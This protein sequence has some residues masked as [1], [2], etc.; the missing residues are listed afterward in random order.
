[1]FHMWFIVIAHVVECAWPKIEYAQYHNIYD[2][3][4]KMV[5]ASTMWITVA[6][7]TI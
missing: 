5:D 6:T 1:M 2:I 3:F 7:I 4:I